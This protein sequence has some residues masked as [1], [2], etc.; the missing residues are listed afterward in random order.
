MLYI[1][2]I[3]T[4]YIYSVKYISDNSEI[5]LMNVKIWNNHNHI[6]LSIWF[7]FYF[8]LVAQHLENTDSSG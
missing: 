3:Y 6:V 5:D 8:G 4:L 1:Y 2:G 7:L